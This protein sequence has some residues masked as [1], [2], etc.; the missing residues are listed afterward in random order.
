MLNAI[1]SPSTV[2][3]HRPLTPWELSSLLTPL[4]IYHRSKK[5]PKPKKERAHFPAILGFVYRNRFAVT[6]QIQRRFSNVLRSD[7][8]AR[9][10]LQE[11]E[12]LGYLAVAPARGVS[13]LFPKVYYVTG[14]G[15]K[16]LQESLAAQGKSWKA[17]RVDR[18]GRHTQE[19]Y[20]A[21]HILHEI[22]ITEFLLAVWQTVQARIDLELLTIQRRS[23]AK[24]SAFRLAGG[25]RRSRLIPDG[26]FLIRYKTGGMICVFLEI[27]TGS[28][29]RKQLKAKFRRYA[30]W[31]DSEDGQR[32]LIDLYTRHG[33]TAARPVFRLM[34]VVKDRANIDDQRR[35][36]EFATVIKNLPTTGIN[37][38][39]IST[40]AKMRTFYKAG[41][42][43]EQSLWQIGN[44]RSNER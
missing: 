15:V 20:T 37:R 4:H 33:A 25:K 5:K 44:M 6:S 2:T 9:R 21:D 42:I 17:V 19:G 8:T 3:K 7:R 30:S 27:D 14:R 12:S 10:H 22:L 43:L 38:L 32:Y 13:P 23:L 1:S 41:N 39:W 24:H 40:T 28:M 18:H 36:R 34:A 31:A 29:N 26:M 11:L 35:L 16:K